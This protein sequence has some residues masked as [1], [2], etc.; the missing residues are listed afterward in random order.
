MDAQTADRIEES[1][2][3]QIT[4]YKDNKHNSIISINILLLNTHL[5]LLWKGKFTTSACK[6]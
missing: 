6:M 5:L 2:D 3:E 1:A 4:R